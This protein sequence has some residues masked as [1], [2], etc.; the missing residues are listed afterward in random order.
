MIAVPFREVY[1][2]M[3]RDIDARYADVPQAT[4]SNGS[5]ESKVLMLQHG[6]RRKWRL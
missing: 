3:T 5:C 1:M 6:T 4:S 2:R